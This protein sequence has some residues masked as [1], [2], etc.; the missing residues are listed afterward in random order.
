MEHSE[1]LLCLLS[2]SFGLV[3]FMSKSV[4][5]KEAICVLI[6]NKNNVSGKMTLYTYNRGKSTRIVCD[7]K[8]LSPG[9]HG[10]HV[11]QTADITDGCDSTC[12]HYNPFGHSHGD[13]LEEY[14][15]R[16][17]LGN[18]IANEKGMCT[19]IIVANVSLDEIIGRTIVI[20]ERVDDLGK[21]SN[22]ESLKTGN[23]GKR[24]ACGIIGHIS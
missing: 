23:S 9:P 8:G 12:G 22:E 18:I 14:R 11:H 5:Y 17:D 6:K 3:F 15:H 10:I 19:D 4:K 2:F 16:G 13:H 24:I 1:L 7:I 20:H 21:S